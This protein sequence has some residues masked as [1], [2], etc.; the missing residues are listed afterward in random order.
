MTISYERLHF[1][2]HPERGLMEYSVD[3]FS[4]MQERKIQGFWRLIS[5]QTYVVLLRNCVSSFKRGLRVIDLGVINLSGTLLSLLFLSYLVK[6]GP[7]QF[8]Q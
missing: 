5:T 1:L 8:S 6:L 7:Y 3:I 4:L 2:S